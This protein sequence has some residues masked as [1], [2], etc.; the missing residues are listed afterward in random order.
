MTVT[1]DNLTGKQASMTHT[2]TYKVVGQILVIVH[3]NPFVI[4][5]ITRKICRSLFKSIK[6]TNVA[7]LDST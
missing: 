7:K 4:K 1:L 2:G 3:S 6:V 5:T